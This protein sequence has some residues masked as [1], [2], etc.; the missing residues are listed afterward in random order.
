MPEPLPHHTELEQKLTQMYRA[1]PPDAAFADRLEQ[2]LRRRAAARPQPA[3]QPPRPAWRFL[4]ALQPLAWGGAAALLVLV[5]AWGVRYLLPAP[6]AGSRVALAPVT[7]TATPWFTP[8]P[9][10]P[11]GQELL[12][13]PTPMPYPTPTPILDYGY[14]LS[15]Q[16]SHADIRQRVISPAWY[17]L[18]VEGQVTYF[19]AGGDITQNQVAMGQAWLDRGVAGRVISTDVQSGDPIRSFMDLTP[20]WV[21]VGSAEGVTSY[22]ILTQETGPAGAVAG[23]I[24]HPLEN[25]SPLVEMLFPHFLAPLSVDVEPIE[26]DWIAGRPVLVVDWSN[27]R[28]WVDTQTG[29][30]LRRQIFDENRN[31]IVEVNLGQIVY[32]PELPADLS[33]LESLDKIQFEPA[34]VSSSMPGPTP[35]PLPVPGWENA[36]PT[37]T[38]Y[39]GPVV[40]PPATEPA[41][42][43]APVTG[44]PVYEPFTVVQPM[45]GD[46]PAGPEGDM[47]DLYFVL[48]DLQPPFGRQ[49]VRIRSAC[50]YQGDMCGAE[51]IPGYPEAQDPPLSWAH[52]GLSAVLLNGAFT[53]YNPRQQTWTDLIPFYPAA[54]TI[55]LWSWD[56]AWVATTVQNEDSSGSV[57]RLV[58]PDGSELRT[59]G[60]D[61]GGIQTPLGWLDNNTLLFLR[62]WTP[63]KGASGEAEPPALYRLDIQ[64]GS[65]SELPQGH[66]WEWTT[67]FPAVSPDGTAIALTMPLGDR[68]ELSVMDRDGNEVMSLGR[69]GRYPVWSRDGS[70]I[71]FISQDE[72]KDALYIVQRDGSGLQKL[73]ELPMAANPPVWSPEGQHIVV[74]GYPTGSEAP[75]FDRPMLFLVSLTDGRVRQVTLLQQNERYEVILPSYRP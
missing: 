23:W 3:A 52:D 67:S 60:A 13:T 17:S 28:M 54:Q 58:R 32:N 70:R 34:P 71:A 18:W 64:S 46:E 25:V 74:A 39:D 57:I 44:A 7:E 20:R 33:S 24:S 68:S 31:L 16:S 6:P 51:L 15:L 37:P 12:P 14:P 63:A 22:D 30:I 45:E 11:S 66:E 2:K 56:Q 43:E 62:T 75:G 4:A 35:T 21:W 19:S 40:E 5:V 55:A 72:G 10:D 65:W 59:F 49:L 50:I 47:G 61:L 53:V 27:S 38:P 26:E 36:T 69:S 1:A 9:F 73:A 29:V 42:T 41:V 8:T 48:R